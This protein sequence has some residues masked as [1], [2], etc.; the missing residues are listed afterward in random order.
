M[1]ENEYMR[2]A[3]ASRANSHYLYSER[4]I[5]NLI[6]IF[7][8][9]HVPKQYYNFGGYKEQSV[10]FEKEASRWI[11]Y[12]GERGNKYDVKKYVDLKMAC[13]DMIGRVSDTDEQEAKMK[14]AFQLKKFSNNSPRLFRVSTKY[15]T[16]RTNNC[17]RRMKPEELEK[18]ISTDESIKESVKQRKGFALKRTRKI[19]RKVY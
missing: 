9:Y 4:R 5:R 3:N 19:R 16:N 12:I 15:C 14:S 2:K 8:E 6:K 11:V 1:N 18:M 7:I 17:P 10:C 13:L